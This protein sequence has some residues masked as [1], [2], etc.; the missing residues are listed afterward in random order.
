MMYGIYIDGHGHGHGYQHISCVYVSETF[1]A[2]EMVAVLF[3]F[4]LVAG[5]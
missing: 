3:G 2:V 5:D 4:V 1:A